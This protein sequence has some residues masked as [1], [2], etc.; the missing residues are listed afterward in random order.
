MQSITRDITRN[1]GIEHYDEVYKYFY[2][3][4]HTN[5]VWFDF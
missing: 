2:R 4:G 5:V 1:R 3:V